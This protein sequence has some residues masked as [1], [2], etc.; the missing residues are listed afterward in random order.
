M[1]FRGNANSVTFEEDTFFNCQLVSGTLKVMCYVGNISH[2][3]SPSI[4]GQSVNCCV[5]WISLD[6]TSDDI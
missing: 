2:S 3:V 6:G 4:Q 1:S 5:Y